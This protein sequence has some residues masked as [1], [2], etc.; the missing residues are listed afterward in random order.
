MSGWMGTWIQGEP[1]EGAP[2][3]RI[4]RDSRDRWHLNHVLA[5]ALTRISLGTK[6]EVRRCAVMRHRLN[7]DGAGPR[8]DLR[9]HFIGLST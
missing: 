4:W 8:P 5:G 7:L 9:R 2:G 3:Y 1:V 6:F